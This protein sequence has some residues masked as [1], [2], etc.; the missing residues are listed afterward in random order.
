VLVVPS[1]LVE[2]GTVVEVLDT[3]K[4]AG[5]ESLALLNETGKGE[6]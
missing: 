6:R 2:L 4:A 3:A 1:D 5:A